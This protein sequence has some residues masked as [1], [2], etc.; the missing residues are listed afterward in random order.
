MIRLSP[1]ASVVTSE[2]ME[3]MPG[4]EEAYVLTTCSGVQVVPGSV[5]S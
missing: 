4:T 5:Y 3:P 2:V 1:L